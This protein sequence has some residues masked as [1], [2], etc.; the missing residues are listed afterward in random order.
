MARPSPAPV[1]DALLA[2]MMV[3]HA[4]PVES[5]NNAREFDFDPTLN[6]AS[7]DQLLT[8]GRI[9]RLACGHF[10][11]SKALVR[12]GCNRCGEMIRAGWDHD[13]F[14]RLGIA[15]TFSWPDDPLRKLHE[16]QNDGHSAHLDPTNFR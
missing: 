10:K 8:R 2:E 7:V 11:T 9:V 6:T 3:A 5:I 13:G 12:T 16:R 4:D 14:R 1:V 15:D